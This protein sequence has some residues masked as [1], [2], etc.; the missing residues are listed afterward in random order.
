MFNEKEISLMRES[1]LNRGVVAFANTASMLQESAFVDSQVKKAKFALMNSQ[2]FRTNVSDVN[3]KINQLVREGNVTSEQAKELKEFTKN[4]E[5]LTKVYDESLKSNRKRNIIT[6]GLTAFVTIIG[7]AVYGYAKANEKDASFLVDEITKRVKP[8][9]SLMRGK[10][11]EVGN[12]LFDGFKEVEKVSNELVNSKEFQQ[13]EK[14]SNELASSK[15]FQQA[16]G[17]VD[18][19]KKEVF[20]RFGGLFE[21]IG[22]SELTESLE[23]VNQQRTGASDTSALYGGMIAA[24]V[25]TTSARILFGSNFWTNAATIVA[26]ISFLALMSKSIATLAVMVTIWFKGHMGKFFDI[27]DS[28]DNEKLIRVFEDDKKNADK[29]KAER[30]RWL[31]SI[32]SRMKMAKKDQESLI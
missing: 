17:S 2:E 27:K 10:A 22:Y 11:E 18:A 5:T 21:S 25:G 4:S 31:K 16:K 14:V 1:V 24:I 3:D 32:I 28:I 26:F 9:N 6:L 8:L 13:V 20:P 23:R 12:S 15:I 29:Q 19:A 30:S 7:V